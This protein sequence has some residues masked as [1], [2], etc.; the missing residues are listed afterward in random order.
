[1]QISSLRQAIIHVKL[2]VYHLQLFLAV[3]ITLAM[4]SGIRCTL[5]KILKCLNRLTSKKAE[6]SAFFG[7]PAADFVEATC[8]TSAKSMN[9]LQCVSSL[10]S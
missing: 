4:A 2:S 8:T 7:A 10:S 6:S 3:T 5:V 1:M 9:P